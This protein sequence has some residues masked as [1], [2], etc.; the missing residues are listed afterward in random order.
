MQGDS[1]TKYTF[2]ALMEL[3]HGDK[4]YCDVPSADK[5]AEDAKY[6][7]WWRQNSKIDKN[8]IKN[9]Q[10]ELQTCKKIETRLKIFLKSKNDVGEEKNDIE[11][12]KNSKFD[13]KFEKK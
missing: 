4:T 12:R 1:T 11:Y 10:N 9:S 6:L 7:A 8:K 5:C 2:L 3:L 13:K